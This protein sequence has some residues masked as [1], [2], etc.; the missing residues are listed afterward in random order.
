[1]HNDGLDAHIDHKWKIADEDGAC[2]VILR[3]LDSR[4]HPEMAPAFLQPSRV[5]CELHTVL[6]LWLA[7]ACGT[8]TGANVIHAAL[9]GLLTISVHH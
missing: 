3:P 7:S 8:L 1:M 2:R 5:C 6:K 9:H 4:I